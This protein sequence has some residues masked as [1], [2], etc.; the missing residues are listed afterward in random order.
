M[1]LGTGFGRDKVNFLRGNLYDTMIW[2]AGNTGFLWSNLLYKRLLF[3]P[4]GRMG[5]KSV[6]FKVFYNAFLISQGKSIK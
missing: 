5:G 2:T 1:A 4:I 3:G 6:V